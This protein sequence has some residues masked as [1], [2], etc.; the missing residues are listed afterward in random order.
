MRWIK[1]RRLELFAA[2]LES[3]PRAAKSNSR[4][5]GLIYL[6]LHSFDLY[7]IRSLL[8]EKTVHPDNFSYCLH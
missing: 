2:D 4:S 8:N 7:N 6:A 5:L 1:N 3:T